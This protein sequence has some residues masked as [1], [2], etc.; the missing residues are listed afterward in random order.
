MNDLEKT[1]EAE[2]VICSNCGA[3]FIITKKEIQEQLEKD[4]PRKIPLNKK[5]FVNCIAYKGTTEVHL[6]N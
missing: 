6:K 5:L 1:K 4:K 3:G 2:E